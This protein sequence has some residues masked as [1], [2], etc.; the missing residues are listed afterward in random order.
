VL[1]ALLN[2]AR[3]ELPIRGTLE[4]PRIDEEALKER[5]KSLGSDMLGNSIVAGAE[6]LL[7]L[8]EGLPRRRE[9]RKPPADAPGA[10]PPPEPQPPRRPS[11]EERRQTR[12]QRRLDRL[13]KK[14]Q[15]RMRRGGP[16]E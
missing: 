5:L 12:E 16:P 7:R 14:A 8:L 9:A 10:G 15:R 13:E 2:D 11:A 1:A 3:F 4:H 6:G